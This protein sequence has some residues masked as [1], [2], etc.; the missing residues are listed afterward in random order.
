MGIVRKLAIPAILLFAAVIVFF[1]QQKDSGI[2]AVEPEPAAESPEGESV[3]PSEPIELTVLL[4]RKYLDGEESEEAVKE[5]IWAMED[6]WAKY[7]S[8]QL[9]DMNE[10]QLLFEK[11]M[12]DIS[13]LMKA[14]GFFGIESDGTLSIFNGK[15]EEKEVIQSFFQIDIQRL[16]SNQHN[17]LKEGIPVKSKEDYQDVIES[18]KHHTLKK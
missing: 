1:F 3:V 16:E 5:T 15:P 4:K 9:V 6:F 14:N 13:P 8:W 11:E 17:R 12:D 10:K 7:D 2:Q 18:M